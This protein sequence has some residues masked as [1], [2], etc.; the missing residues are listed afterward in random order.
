MT[1][2]K[3]RS[4]R[5]DHKP[6]KEE[7]DLLETGDE[8][9]AAAL[10]STFTGGRI[11]TSGSGKGG[12]ACHKIFS[13]HHHRLQLKTA[14]ASSNPPGAPA[15]PL[16]NSSGTTTSQSQTLLAG[17]NPI[18]VAA[19][20]GICPAH[21]PVHECVFKGDVRRLSS[22]IRTHNIGQ[23]DNHGNTPLHLA[24]M[25]GNKE[26]AHLLLAHNAPVK[27]KNAQG[28]SPLAEAIS[29]GDR[30]MITALLRK[31]K[32]QS[33]E[34]VEEKRPR[35]LKALKECLYFPEFCLLMLVKYTN[36]VSISGLTLLS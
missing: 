17:T 22:L 23:K 19:D 15:L 31:L 6:S 12:K 16:H 5:R 9:A 32:Q 11:G 29:Y 34:S 20:G 33:R 14:P 18:A 36:K 35:L 24:V 4:L 21:Y 30:Q 25:L 7:G 10:G 8:E 3:I 1:G 27:V 28:W 26:C 13:N 2:E